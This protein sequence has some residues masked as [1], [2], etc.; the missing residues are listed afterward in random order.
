VRPRSV[1]TLFAVP[2]VTNQNTSRPQRADASIKQTDMRRVRY[3]DLEAQYE[4]IRTEV[5][6]ALG[7]ICESGKFAQGPATSDFEAKFAAYCGVH[8]CVSLNSGTSALHLALRCL[9]IVPGDEVITVAMTFIGT[10]WAISYVGAK[11]V[12]V[13]ID[14]ARR[15]MC[16]S[17]L[18]TAITPRTKAIIPVHLYGMPAEMDRIKAIADRRG[19]P[20]IE[21]AAQAH[22]A[23]YR[24][25]RVGQFGQIACFSFYPSKNLGAYGEGGA[26]VTN[27]ASIAQRARSLRDHAQSQ[28]YLHDEIGYNYRMDSFQAA[29][30]AIKL[31]R[32]DA[33]N[34][35]RA[36]R[37]AYYTELLG[38]SSY[39]LPTHFSDSECVWHCY[40]IEAPERHRVRS[41]LHE[42]G[43]ET[44][45]HYPVPV[46]LQKAYAHLGYKPGD[47]PVTERLCQ[48]C[49][50]LPIYPELS[51]EKIFTVASILLD[52]ERERSPI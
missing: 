7:E 13:D 48:H 6:A 9:D 11:P 15:T 50:S 38:N 47:L 21:D 52:L 10:A 8:H 18:E 33:W 4:D 41:V 49:L 40:V 20:V 24:D 17:K 5:L 19:L 1:A 34:A 44:G 25:K 3:L 2:T 22:G 46:H 30:L 51:K 26:L 39:K 27:D 45:V 29:V 37:A 35:A 16:P 43:I 28:K 36:D 12:F 23:R 32:L 14:P 31:K 42:A